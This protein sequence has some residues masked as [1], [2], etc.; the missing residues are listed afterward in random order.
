TG[1]YIKQLYAQGGRGVMFYQGPIVNPG[2]EVNL[3]V[4]GRLMCDVSRGVED[5]LMQVLE[6]RYRPKKSTS[7]R[8]LADVFLKSERAYFDNWQEAEIEKHD[9]VP[10]PGELHLGPLF[11]D[12]PGGPTYL[13][14][15]FL[16]A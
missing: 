4:G 9:K 6:E 7:L 2:V 5:V 15:P 1:A 16:N 13:N 3:A 10:P 8:T 14:E 11:G 12:S